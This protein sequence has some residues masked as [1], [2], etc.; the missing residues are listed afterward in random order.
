MHPVVTDEESYDI[1]I[2]IDN[3]PDETLAYR[4]SSMG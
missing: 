2:Y 3:I 1:V 4:I